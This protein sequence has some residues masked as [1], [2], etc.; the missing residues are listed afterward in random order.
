MAKIFTGGKDQIAGGI[1]YK[2]DSFGCVEI[3]DN[4][5]KCEGLD[6]EPEKTKPKPKP[7]KT[8]T[9]RTLDQEA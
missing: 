9:V 5:A 6:A 4:V 7:K 1:V 8:A 3:P 2:P